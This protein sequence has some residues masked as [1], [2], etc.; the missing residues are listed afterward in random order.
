MAVIDPYLMVQHLTLNPNDLKF[1]VPF[2][3][4]VSG[5]TQGEKY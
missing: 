4:S 1:K 3:M 5:P 2:S